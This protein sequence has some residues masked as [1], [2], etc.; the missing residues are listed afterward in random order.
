[1]SHDPWKEV[2]EGFDK[3]LK[4]TCYIGFVWVFIDILPHLPPHLVDRII[5]GLLKKLGL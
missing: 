5:D 2:R 1:M 3:W 4:L